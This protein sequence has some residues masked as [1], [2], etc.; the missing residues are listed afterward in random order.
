MA[1]STIGA[2]NVANGLV[3]ADDLPEN[4]AGAEECGITGHLFTESSGLLQAIEAFAAD[5]AANAP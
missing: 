3:V 5:R 1:G 2:S 4:I